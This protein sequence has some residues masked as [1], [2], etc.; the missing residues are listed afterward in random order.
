MPN[1]WRTRRP[2]ERRLYIDPDDD[3]Q[4]DVLAP[5][6]RAREPSGD[7]VAVIELDPSSSPS[8]TRAREDGIDAADTPRYVF[9]DE[10]DDTVTEG[11]GLDFIEAHYI[12]GEVYARLADQKDVSDAES[13]DLP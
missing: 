4:T 12:N 9:R 3:F 1:A 6:V 10:P 13:D 11:G 7:E 5:A 8:S 2:S